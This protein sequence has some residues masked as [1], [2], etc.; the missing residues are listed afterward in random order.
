MLFQSAADPFLRVGI[1]SMSLEGHA[2]P[3]T[4]LGLGQTA[5]SLSRMLAPFMAGLS[6]AASNDGPNVIGALSSFIGLVGLYFLCR[7][8][9]SFGHHEKKV[10]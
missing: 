4:I 7:S 9:D 1:T 2:D 5:T 6:Q 3:G 8:K 10:S